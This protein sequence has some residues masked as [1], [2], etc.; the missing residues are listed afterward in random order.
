MGN[1][2]LPPSKLSIK[3]VRNFSYDC[4]HKKER[5]PN[6]KERPVYGR[7]SNKD[8]IVSNAIQMILSTPRQLPKQEDWTKKKNYG[9]TPAYLTHIKDTLSSEYKLMQTLHE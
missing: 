1:H 6:A 8:F 2:D 3:L 9:K 4:A 5:V 7:S